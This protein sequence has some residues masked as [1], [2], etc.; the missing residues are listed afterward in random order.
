LVVL[1][2]GVRLSALVL[3]VPQGL[4][5]VAPLTP[6]FAAK[7]PIFVARLMLT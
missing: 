4:S 2:P 6:G 3:A 1:L 7:M 5:L